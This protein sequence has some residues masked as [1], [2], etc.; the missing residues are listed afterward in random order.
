M[1]RIKTRN[2]ISDKGLVAMQPPLFKVGDEEENPHAILVRSS[3]ISVEEL[4]GDL[5]AIARA[6]A[7][8]NN[9][10]VEECTKKGIVV[11]N[12]PGANANAVKELTIAA[13]IA[14][15]RNLGDGVVWA[16]TLK[17]KGEEVPSLVEKGKN[18]F[19]GPEI[20]GKKLGII[21]LGAIG[22]LV[23]NVA[24]HLG[25]E[26]YG[27]DPFI[28]VQAAWNLSRSV[29]P[30]SNLADLLSDCDFIS[31]HL[32]VNKDTKGFVNKELLN[33]MKDGARIINMARG[34]LVVNSD[35]I[36][37]LASGK[38]CGY[39]TDFPSDELIDVPG[40]LAIPHLGASTPESE[41]NCA[42]MAV[43]QTKA[44][45][46]RG[47]IQNSVNMPNVALED[48]EGTRICIF[49]ENRSGMLSAI[50]G[51]AGEAELN[52]ENLVNKSR[53][54]IAYTVLD[55]PCAVDKSVIDRFASIEGVIRT[56]VICSV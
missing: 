31:L 21:G 14:G 26:V 2:S 22:V 24:V 27:Y 4:T 41:E 53:G 10:P 46:K 54:D 43:G 29:K 23:A 42:I 28:S 40:V 39:I 16:K 52:I 38:I 1:H 45:L 25:M 19:V 3:K 37:A 18:Q 50:T 55:V 32:P 9:I 5:V 34:D 44:Y 36:S 12:T 6:G 47:E 8:Y 7:G 33:K 35:I 30:C 11:F 15:C 48:F 51:L 56:R 17:G 20:G 13:L 49:N